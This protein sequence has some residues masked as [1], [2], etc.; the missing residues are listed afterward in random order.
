VSKAL[1][2][3]GITPT[4][5]F[6]GDRKVDGWPVQPLSDDARAELQR[7][8]DAFY[9]LFLETV[10]A[11]RGRKLSQKAARD[12]QARTFIGSAAVDAGLADAVGS[13]EEVLVEATAKARRGNSAASPA[14]SKSMSSILG[15]R[16]VTEE[17]SARAVATAR[18]EGLAEGE[19][20]GLEVGAAAE[21]TRIRAIVQDPRMVG[22]ESAALD[23]AIDAPTMS[24]DAVARFLETRVPAAAAAAPSAPIAQ[25]IEETGVNAI[26]PGQQAPAAGAPGGGAVVGPG[27][28]W[29]EFIPA[30]R[31][32]KR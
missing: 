17:E 8:V 16:T 15:D 13:F 9:G 3:K 7:E 14:R 28:D 11:G 2:Q 4:L 29:R 19:R 20:R 24:A 31:Q 25:R 32:K 6:A 5:I 27:R 12:T 23:L 22:R 18:A 26:Q 10:A 1:E 30:N 21:R